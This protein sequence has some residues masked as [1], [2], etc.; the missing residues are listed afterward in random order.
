MPRVNKFRKLFRRLLG[1]TNVCLSTSARYRP[2]WRARFPL[3]LSNSAYL[4]PT[5]KNGEG[6][7]FCPFYRSKLQLKEV[8][9]F[10]QSYKIYWP[11]EKNLAQYTVYCIQKYT[12]SDG[13]SSIP[14]TMW[15]KRVPPRCPVSPHPCG[16][17]TH[18]CVP[19][20][21]SPTQTHMCCGCKREAHW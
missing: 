4:T 9:Q 16:M 21:L 8:E 1:T 14:G 20:T 6:A 10:F 19:W 3:Y 15:K 11:E 17:C 7:I 12:V 2:S 18:R 5:L 13:L